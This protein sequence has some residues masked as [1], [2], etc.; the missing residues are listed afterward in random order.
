MMKKIVAG[1]I[2]VILA[3]VVVGA[4]FLF[5]YHSTQTSLDQEQN[6]LA[7]SSEKYDQAMIYWNENEYANGKFRAGFRQLL[8]SK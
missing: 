5:Q 2:A 1:V 4:I 6:L 3:I 7:S 8:C